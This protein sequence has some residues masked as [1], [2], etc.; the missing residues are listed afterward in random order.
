MYLFCGVLTQKSHPSFT[1]EGELHNLED[2]NWGFS[3]TILNLLIRVGGLFVWKKQQK[4]KLGFIKWL[5]K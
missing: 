1:L 3:L 5:Q 4:Y 2:D